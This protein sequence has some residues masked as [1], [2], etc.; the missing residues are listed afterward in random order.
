M[1][2]FWKVSESV[3]RVSNLKTEDS[4]FNNNQALTSYLIQTPT[5]HYWGDVKTKLGLSEIVY[6]GEP[7][8]SVLT[9]FKYKPMYSSRVELIQLSLF[10]CTSECHKLLYKA[11]SYAV[12]IRIE[13]A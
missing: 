3:R 10:H 1:Y 5:G 11:V 6:S 4:W 9:K 7:Q 13:T 2:N 12:S 8:D